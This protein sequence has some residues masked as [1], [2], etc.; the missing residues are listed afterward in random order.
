MSRTIHVALAGYGFAG[1]TFHAPLIQSVAGLRL[2]RIVSTDPARVAAEYP[3]IP[4]VSYDDILA[5]GSVDLIVIATPHRAHAQMAHRA[6]A[7]G[8]HV[9]IEKPM[10]VTTEEAQS[11]CALASRAGTVASVFHN[12]RWD[13]DFLTLRALLAEQRLGRV[14]QLESRFDR[15]RPVARDRW[16]ERPEPG[17]GTWFDLG[18]HLL[19]QALQ[20]FGEPRSVYAELSSERASSAATDFFHVRLRYADVRVVLEGSSLAVEPGPRFR[21]LGTDATYTKHGIDVQENALRGGARPLTVQPWGEDPR[22]G[23]LTRSANGHAVAVEVPNAR[24]KYM[25]FYAGVRDAIQ[26]IVPF[27]PVTLPEAARVVRGL[28]LAERSASEARELPWVPEPGRL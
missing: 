18:S 1:R 13:A 24:G 5:D 25:G 26:G 14:V 6:I 27:P 4:V 11:L 19:D 8:K 16:R 17:A 21:V 3:D 2:H 12:R 7:A 10:A 23:L 22:S 9:V 28:T 20:L 15:Y